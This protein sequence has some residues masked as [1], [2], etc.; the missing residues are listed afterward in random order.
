MSLSFSTPLRRNK[1]R[2]NAFIISAGSSSSFAIDKNGKT[3]GWGDN[4][5]GK[6]GNNT[7][8]ERT[9]P[10][11]I[12]G[13]VKTFCQIDNGSTFCSAIDK[14][15]LVWGWGYG[16]Y[17]QLGNG[18]TTGAM[19]TPVSVTGVRKTFCKVAVGQNHVIA[20]DQYGRAWAWGINQYGQL[21]DNTTVSKRTPISVL[22]AVKTF[23]SLAATA[24]LGSSLAIDKNGRVWGWGYNGRG[25]LGSN[26]VSQQNTPVAIAGVLKTFCKIAMGNAHTIAIDKNGRLWGWG[27]NRY[28]Q[29]GNNGTGSQRTPV[30]ILGAVKTFCHINNGYDVSYALDKNGRAWA[31]GNNSGGVLGDGSLIDR[32][33]PVSVAGTIKTFCQISGGIAHAIAVDKN[34][35][36]WGWGQNDIGPLGIGSFPFK[37]TPAAIAGSIKTF[38]EIYSDSHVAAID[39][40]GR[41]WG[42]GINA[43]Y[44]TL[45][46]G[47]TVIMRKTP[48]SL[49]G[50]VKTFCK[51]ITSAGGVH[52]LA[53]YKNG[54]AWGWGW[55]GYLQLGDGTSS[56]RCTPVSVAGAVKTFCEIGAG[57]GQGSAID[58][59]GQVWMW[60]L[61]NTNQ[62]GN[63][64]FSNSATPVK[65][66]GLVK[67]FCKISTGE[68]WTLAI[69]KN[70]QVWAWGR[71]ANNQTGTGGGVNIATPTKIIGLA[72][73]FCKVE[74]A[75]IHSMA[76]DK[77]GRAWGWGDNGYGKIG[78]NTVTFRTSPVSVAG[79]VKTFCHISAG[80]NH[81]LAI[82]KNGRAWAW[83]FNHRGQLG[84][85]SRTS[86][87]TPVSVAG[88]IKTFC[89]INSGSNNSIA[90]D[91]N[92]KVWAWGDNPFGSNG[93]NT[94]A[95]SE[96]PVQICS[97]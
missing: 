74:A 55:N 91:K 44:G 64:T 30:S 76:I 33:T 63:G 53:I 57:R 85:N 31:W 45:G 61:N 20:I 32:F 8:T 59:N 94:S 19:L 84:D 83:G 29:L 73:T 26:S 67:T 70:G 56:N 24:V 92:G 90:I 52:T 37:C 65:I 97:I 10:T 17:G 48:V 2:R 5:N 21:G 39:K 46:D 23:C 72:K 60:G 7:T 27:Y 1:P 71:N 95:L 54:R 62:L 42:W 36:S 4:T 86:R 68:N 80:P 43:Q 6:L 69:E 13:S 58:K 28:G 14:N 82:D 47:T 25:Q 78:D 77:N 38:C 66:G 18:T 81:T 15:G 93:D 51:I 96:T 3:W 75:R 79:A 88:A 34:G 40:N 35:R 11:S 50:A 49:A 9:T 41:I 87:R 16:N 22:G 89:K 12:A